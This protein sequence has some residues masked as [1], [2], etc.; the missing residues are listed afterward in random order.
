MAITFYAL[1]GS[2][3][4]WRV[5]FALEHKALPYHLEMLSM[6]QKDT[7]KPEFTKLNPRQKVPL[8]IDEGLILSESNAIVEY[9]DECYPLS[10]HG[11]LFPTE[12]K[13]RALV[14]KVISE[15]DC[16]LMPHMGTILRQLF[17]KAEAEWD[18]KIIA[19]AEDDLCNELH[20]IEHHFHGDYLVE[21]LSA[22]DY[23]LYPLIATLHRMEKKKNDLNVTATLGPK[24]KD[25]KKRIESLPYFMN[26]FPP[27]WK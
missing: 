26:T 3:Y 25:W 22:A 8:I 19:A 11:P 23:A 12:I 15:V 18:N 1:S 16:Y 17:F 14:R 4:V 2:P 5:W 9:L 6:T 10:G 27:H 7:S 20:H 24:I 21:N 13:Q